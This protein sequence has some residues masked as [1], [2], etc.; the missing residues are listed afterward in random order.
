MAGSAGCWKEHMLAAQCLALTNK[1]E[2]P[3]TDSMELTA[4]SQ[5]RHEEELTY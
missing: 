1:K 2:V 4:P 3:G 5:E